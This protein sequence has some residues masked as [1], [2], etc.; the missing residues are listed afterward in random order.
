MKIPGVGSFDVARY[1]L[2][3]YKAEMRDW[4]EIEQ[5]VIEALRP[6]AKR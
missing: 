2:N 6:F 4:E 1:Q 3:V 5:L